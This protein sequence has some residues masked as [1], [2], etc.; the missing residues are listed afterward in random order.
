MS[1]S[2]E[3]EEFDLSERRSVERVVGRCRSGGISRSEFVRHLAV[4]GYGEVSSRRY[5]D[6][7]ETTLDG[8][9]CVRSR[10]YLSRRWSGPA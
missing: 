1:R 10:Q 3:Y 4:L 7:V 9:G 2:L 5:A 6:L 8:G